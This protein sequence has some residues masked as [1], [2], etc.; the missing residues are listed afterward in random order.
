MKLNQRII[1]SKRSVT[2]EVNEKV[3][4]IKKQGEEVYN[5]SS[6]QL[7]FRPTPEFIQSLISQ[8]NFLSSF[9]YPSVQGRKDLREK[10]SQSYQKNRKI[11]L[12]SN[13]E[14]II[15][16]GSKHSI[17]NALGAILNP[18]DEV[19]LLSP[20]WVSYPEMIR[21][22][23]GIPKV[24]TTHLYDSYTPDLLRIKESITSKTKAIIIN[25]PN[26][27]AGI[28][29]DEN[30][31]KGF[32]SMIQEFPNLFLFSDEV[33]SDI[34]YYDPAPSYFYQSHPN[35]LGRTIIING[36]SKSFA[37]TGLRVGYCLAPQEVINA[38]VIIQSQTTS[39]ASSLV[40]KALS[41]F[42]FENLKFFHD[43]IKSFLRNSSEILREELRK[44]GLAHCWYQTNSAFYF[45]L[46]FTRTNAFQDI[47]EDITDCSSRLCMDLLETE[48]V[49]VVPGSSFGLLNSAR[50]SLT[51]EPTPFKEGLKRLCRYLNK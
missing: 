24:I 42:D 45:M 6:G 13:H 1:D 37:S 8:T 38:M 7:S 18:G 26:N 10:I 21:F 28:Y 25:S 34:Y 50:I 2:M 9:Q 4:Q 22:W 31:M 15:S 36:I 35:L 46:D 30:W 43:E 47:Q 3:N 5:L 27:P 51:I 39:G 11:D 40:Q 16:N 29:Y 23:G 20:Y 17:Y 32:G 19:I 49:A 12:G 41:D 14:V 33:Y 48:K 44:A